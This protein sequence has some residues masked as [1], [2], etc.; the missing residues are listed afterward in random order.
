MLSVAPARFLRSGSG[1]APRFVKCGSPRL[2]NPRLRLCVSIFRIHVFSRWRCVRCASFNIRTT[3]CSSQARAPCRGRVA[4]TVRASTDQDR[5]EQRCFTLTALPPPA[6]AVLR[7]LLSSAH[8]LCLGQANPPAPSLPGF[9]KTSS[10]VV[11]ATSP[12]PTRAA[13]H[14]AVNQYIRDGHVVGLGT[15]RLVSIA[16]EF[17]SKCALSQFDS[18][19]VDG[20]TRKRF[21]DD[22][23]LQEPPRGV[24]PALRQSWM[25]LAASI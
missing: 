19:P 4:F 23:D 24:R 9:S 12:F 17:I 16:A 13:A 8:L 20:R 18:F 1:H 10:V 6:R 22:C 2:P 25:H 7:P 5:A 3:N 14:W 11:T 15:G 21:C